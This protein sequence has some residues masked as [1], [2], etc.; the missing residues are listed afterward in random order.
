MAGKWK[1]F[2]FFELTISSF[3]TTFLVLLTSDIRHQTS[4]GVFEHLPAGA[5]MCAFSCELEISRQNFFLKLTLCAALT[6]TA[7]TQILYSGD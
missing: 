3:F 1:P 5:I 6:F 2:V 7:S 4:V